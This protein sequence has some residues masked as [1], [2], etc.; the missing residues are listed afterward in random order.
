VEVVLLEDGIGEIGAGGEGELLGKDEGIV[1]IEE[2]G[3]DLG[4]A[5]RIM[6]GRERRLVYF[7]HGE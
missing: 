7:C 6:L 5:V 1:A 4:H 2:E 3:S